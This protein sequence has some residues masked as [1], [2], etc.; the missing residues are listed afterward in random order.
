M[1][2]ND[3]FKMF[4]EYGKCIIVGF[5]YLLYFKKVKVLVFLDRMM[6]KD[7]FLLGFSLGMFKGLVIEL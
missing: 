1:K 2:S 5:E 3:I 4:I 7:G 6:V